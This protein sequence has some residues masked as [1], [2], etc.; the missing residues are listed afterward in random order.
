V[1][2]GARD[3]TAWLEIVYAPP[4]SVLALPIVRVLARRDATAPLTFTEQP[5]GAGAADHGRGGVRAGGR[6][7]LNTARA[8]AGL[9]PVRLADVQSAT[10]A[11]VARQYFAA[12]LG[13]AGQ[14]ALAPG[15]NRRD[16]HHRARAAGGVA[17]GGDDSSTAR[18]VSVLAPHTR[19]AGRWLDTALAMPLGRWALMARDWTRSRWGPRC[20]IGRRHR[21]GRV[22]LSLPQE[23][24]PQR[25]RQC[26]ARTHRARARND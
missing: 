23:R 16:Q 10:A 25:G 11:R 3:A 17:G 2:R 26:A 15:A 7:G 5:Y 20:W 24:R 1:S 6:R 4:R 8:A 13:K 12:A 21:G 19:D 18:F 9:Q 22:R 14:G